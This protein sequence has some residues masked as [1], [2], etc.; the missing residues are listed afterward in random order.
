[1]SS[2]NDTIAKLEPTQMGWVVPGIHATVKFLA[3]D[4]GMTSHGK[5]VAGALPAKVEAQ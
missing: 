2:I 3:K 1:M 5:I 4:L